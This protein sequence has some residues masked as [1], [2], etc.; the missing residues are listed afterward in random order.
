M[1]EHIP[2]I[3]QEIMK[4]YE[5]LLIMNTG[6]FNEKTIMLKK[7]NESIENTRNLI[8][9]NIE[10]ND[11]I[12]FCISIIFYNKKIKELKEYQEKLQ[13]YE[14]K[15]REFDILLEPFKNEISKKL[16]INPH[17]FSK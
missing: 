9:E 8:F 10:R 7:I 13:L 16:S 15:K 3:P 11:K 6:I 17:H 12:S 14:T 5:E 4:I 2:D 1:Y